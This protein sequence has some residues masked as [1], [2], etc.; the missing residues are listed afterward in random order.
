LVIIFGD[1]VTQDLA[2]SH[3]AI[4]EWDRQITNAQ[5]SIRQIA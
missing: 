4:A 5:D 2:I 1:L 3:G